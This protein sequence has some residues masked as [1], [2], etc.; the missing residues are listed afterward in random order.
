MSFLIS[1]LCDRVYV[2]IHALFSIKLLCWKKQIVSFQ[3]CSSVFSVMVCNLMI[4]N[5]EVPL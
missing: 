3:T 5:R 1:N 2:L 4:L